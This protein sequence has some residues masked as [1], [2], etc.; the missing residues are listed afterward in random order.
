MLTKKRLWV[1]GI[2]AGIL[3]LLIALL[4]ISGIGSVPDLQ[5]TPIGY[6]DR[7]FNTERIHSI[8]I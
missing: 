6:E 7:I 3:A 5:A 4:L 8:D 1:I 2:L